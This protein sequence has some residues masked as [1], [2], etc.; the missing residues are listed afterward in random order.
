MSA[1]DPKR[2]TT[3]RRRRDADAPVP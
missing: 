2:T 1:P 3:P